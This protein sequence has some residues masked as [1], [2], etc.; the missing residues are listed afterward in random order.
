[1]TTAPLVGA[2]D[3]PPSGGVFRDWDGAQLDPE[4]V[5]LGN[6]LGA[7]TPDLDYVEVDG[8]QVLL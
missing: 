3:T 1:M 4:T 8:K 7:E 5:A 6:L 2:P